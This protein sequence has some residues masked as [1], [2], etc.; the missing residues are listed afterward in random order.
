MKTK[1]LHVRMPS[2]LFDQIKDLARC[3]ERSVAAELRALIKEKLAE[4]KHER[5][6]DYDTERN[7]TPAR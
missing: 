6:G 5:K 2:D 4:S 1:Q 7:T 3:H